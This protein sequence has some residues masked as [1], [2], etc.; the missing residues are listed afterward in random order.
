[1]AEPA[2]AVALAGALQM[3]AEGRLN[4]RD[5]VAVMVTGNGLKDIASVRAAAEAKPLFVEPSLQAVE[6]ILNIP[7]S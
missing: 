4:P 5:R 6:H 1:M 3:A 2:G 7:D